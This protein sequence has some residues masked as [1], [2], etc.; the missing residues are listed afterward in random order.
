MWCSAGLRP[1]PPPQKKVNGSSLSA[2]EQFLIF[3]LQ[4]REDKTGEEVRLFI[5]EGQQERP[6]T[7]TRPTGARSESCLPPLNVRRPVFQPISEYKA[8]VLQSGRCKVSQFCIFFYHS[9]SDYYL[10][11]YVMWNTHC[12]W[13][14]C[15]WGFSSVWHLY[16]S[17][18]H[19]QLDTIH[20]MEILHTWAQLASMEESEMS[21]IELGAKQDWANY[22][23]SFRDSDP[24]KNEQK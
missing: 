22:E 3:G 5:R 4:C 12:S 17:L 10:I 18:F 15:G 16:S 2:E 24:L 11:V 20:K 1:F 6:A 13:K 8:E 19:S 21:Q 7:G 9:S 14:L 23:A